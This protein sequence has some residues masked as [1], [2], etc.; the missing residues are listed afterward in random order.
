MEASCFCIALNKHSLNSLDF[1][2]LIL[3]LIKYVNSTKLRDN[4]YQFQLVGEKV[5]IYRLQNLHDLLTAWY[6]HVRK[7]KNRDLTRRKER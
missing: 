2:N 3:I 5:E 7:K 4:M 6:N 1:L